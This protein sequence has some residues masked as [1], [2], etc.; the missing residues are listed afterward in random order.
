MAGHIWLGI[1]SLPLA[2]LHSGFHL[3]GA[4]PATLMVLFSLTF[5]SGLFGLVMQNLIPK[6]SLRWLPAETIYSQIEHISNQNIQDL[7]NILTAACGP[8]GNVAA[9]TLD[10]LP[11]DQRAAI[12]VGAIRQVGLVQGRSLKSLNVVAISQDREILWTAM[13]DLEPFLATGRVSASSLA[14]EVV[15]IS[16]FRELRRSCQPA[17]RPIIDRMEEYYQQRHQFDLQKRLHHWL[18][19]W[20]PIHVALSVAVSVLLVAHIYT[21]LIYW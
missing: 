3:G 13:K 5:L 14:N 10:D 11:V 16:W 1:I 18:H 17:A 20:L 19:V 8:Q 2:I 7:R 15:G 9:S 6:L 4:L 21:A 12:V